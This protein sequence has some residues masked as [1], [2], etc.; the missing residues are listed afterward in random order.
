MQSHLVEYVVVPLGD[1]VVV[2][3]A[4]HRADE[5]LLPVLE[6]V[7]VVV[8]RRVVDGAVHAAGP[9]AAGTGDRDG[10]VGV[11]V[12]VHGDGG[13]GRLLVSWGV[14]SGEG[15]FPLVGQAVLVGVPRER[16]EAAAGAGRGGVA[17]EEV[18]ALGHVG[19]AVAVGVVLPRVGRPVLVGP[20]REAVAVDNRRGV[21]VGTGGV[22]AGVFVGPAGGAVLG[23]RGGDRRARSD[24]AADVVD[25]GRKHHG[26]DAL[27]REV[28][29]VV[30][31]V[32][33]RAVEEVRL[34]AVGAAVAVGVGVQRVG[35]VA[36]PDAHAGAVVVVRGELGERHRPAAGI[37]LRPGGVAVGVL[38]QEVRVHEL[39]VG[40]ERRG[41]G[42]AGDAPRGARIER[43]DG[44]PDLAGAVKLVL[45][46][47][48]VLVDMVVEE[49]DVLRGWA[50]HDRR[51][52]GQEDGRPLLVQLLAEHQP[53]A[54]VVLPDAVGHLRGRGEGRPLGG[55]AGLD[56]VD[57][58][59]GVHLDRL[60]EVVGSAAHVDA[61]PG[62]LGR[63][64]ADEVGA[65]TGHGAE[66]AVGHDVRRRRHVGVGDAA[67]VGEV[68]D[69]RPVAVD[70]LI[71]DVEAL[72]EVGVE[73]RVPFHLAVSIEDADYGEFL[74]HQL[75]L[76][77][78]VGVGG[79]EVG[80]KRVG[81][82]DEHLVAV[83]QAVAV[84]VEV[85]RIGAVLELDEVVE[86]VAVGVNVGEQVVWHVGVVDAFDF[87]G[88]NHRRLGWVLGVVAA[89]DQAAVLAVVVD[90]A[91][92]GTVPDV[93][94]VAVG[95]LVVVGVGQRRVS[96]V[97]GRPE[98]PRSLVRRVMPVLRTPSEEAHVLERGEGG[99][100]VFLRIGVAALG[101]GVEHAGD[102]G[103][104]VEVV[105]PAADLAPRVE[106]HAARHP[107]G[108][109]AGDELRVLH[110]LRRGQV[111][112]V[113][114][115][116]VKPAE[117]VA[118]ERAAVVEDAEAGVATDVD[119]G[120]GVEVEVAEVVGGVVLA[121]KD[122]L[123]LD[124][125]I[126]AVVV[127]VGGR[128]HR[129]EWLGRRGAG[130]RVD[131]LDLPAAA[132][133]V[134]HQPAVEVVV[135]LAR[136]IAVAG[137]LALRGCPLAALRVRL[138][139][140]LEAGGDAERAVVVGDGIGGRIA[141]R[142]EERLGVALGVQPGLLELAHRV[143]LGGALD[144]DVAA[145]EAGGGAV[146]GAGRRARAVGV[147]DYVLGRDDVDVELVRRLAAVAV[148]RRHRDLGVLGVR[149]LEL[150]G[151]GGGGGLRGLRGIG[152][153]VRGGD[154]L[155]R[156]LVVDVGE[157]P[158]DGGV[159]V[160][161][162]GRDVGV[163]PRELDR[164]ARRPFVGGAL[165]AGPVL[166]AGHVERE[167]RRIVVH[168]RDLLLDRGVVLGPG[169][170]VAGCGVGDHLGLDEKRG[171][172]HHRAGA[173][174][175]A[176]EVEIDLDAVAGG[177]LRRLEGNHDALV[178]VHLHH[179]VG[180]DEMEDRARVVLVVGRQRH[181]N[182]Q[183]VGEAET[184]AAGHAGSRPLGY[185]DREEVVVLVGS[186]HI[187]RAIALGKVDNHGRHVA[188]GHGEKVFGV[189]EDVRFV[190]LH[191]AVLQLQGDVLDLPLLL[192][193]KRGGGDA[194]GIDRGD[195]VLRVAVFGVTVGPDPL[196]AG[197]AARRVDGADVGHLDAELHR[198]RRGDATGIARAV[199]HLD[200]VRLLAAPDAVGRVGR[201]DV[202]D[203][204]R[205]GAAQG[206]G[207]D[208]PGVRVKPVLLVLQ[209]HAEVDAAPLDVAVQELD[210]RPHRVLGVV[211]RGVDLEAVRR[212]RGVDEVGARLVHRHDERVHLG[213]RR[214]REHRADVDLL[215]FGVGR[216]GVGR[217]ALVAALEGAG[218]HRERRQGLDGEDRALQGGVAGVAHL[219]PHLH[220]ALER[221]ALGG[222]DDREGNL[223]VL[224][225]VNL[226]GLVHL[227]AAED[228]DDP[229]AIGVLLGE[230]TPVVAHGDVD[231]HRVVLEA[232]GRDG[233][234]DDRLLVG[235]LHRHVA[236]G[237]VLELLVSLRLRRLVDAVGDDYADR[238]QLL[239]GAKRVD[240]EVGLGLAA[241]HRDL[242]EGRGARRVG[243]V[244]VGNE[245]VLLRHRV[246]RRRAD[247]HHQLHLHVVVVK[248]LGEGHLHLR[249]DRVGAR[250]LQRDGAVAVRVG[251]RDER[252][253]RGHH[254]HAAGHQAAIHDLLVGVDRRDLGGAEDDVSPR[255]HRG[256]GPAHELEG[257]EAVRRQLHRINRPRHQLALDAVRNRLARDA[258]HGEDALV[259]APDVDGGGAAF[260][261]GGADNRRILARAVRNALIDV[262]P[263]LVGGIS[264]IGIGRLEV[265]S[266]HIKARIDVFRKDMAPA[267][268]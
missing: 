3:P 215:A 139:R 18:A 237:A 159:L 121:R 98:E 198:R 225:E 213:C 83:G 99:V 11:A 140:E 263:D 253:R 55:D 63:Q 204:K 53:P 60:A 153:R 85:D 267:R 114:I 42:S 24:L 238:L 57:P 67:A 231:V 23:D 35:T 233:G 119:V 230:V 133:L 75:G 232:R 14:G 86:A 229:V 259:L 162:V 76:G 6:T 217:D 39:V 182:I 101:R 156:A 52:G 126:S 72:A 22:V 221:I 61:L 48:A 28:L 142:V 148:A 73:D 50:L 111:V 179:A 87:L 15:D 168:E 26:V 91:D 181:F 192:E 189:T 118:G 138:R 104:V 212:R 165:V 167:L 47:P 195:L 227:G 268:A 49:R 31:Q 90:V 224:G 94:L 191:V 255:A 264:G 97:L 5:V 93:V 226:V 169:L 117:V 223:L 17:I 254:A 154:D 246:D 219:V 183:R 132:V 81:F 151:A 36:L 216:V 178:V 34:P 59:P 252:R 166:G 202:G 103:A 120:D 78:A 207:V 115:E 71:A 33:G 51:S 1:G 92:M 240:V 206:I 220:R 32:R 149:H 130:Q 266:L 122:R 184:L 187:V 105:V 205:P 84:G 65:S 143:L 222:D 249:A 27:A 265:D 25:G 247:A 4:A 125:R 214:R 44:H 134:L 177:L 248:R 128:Q 112:L 211:A 176:V 96:R 135:V 194:V 9:G 203:G 106:R 37:E 38:Q 21:G 141:G 124:G 174:V 131:H 236:V 209:H 56:E 7:V 171:G 152:N 155:H 41:V 210:R 199:G 180:V 2:A 251:E 262:A 20:L 200:A 109:V 123:H 147:D 250:R 19:D 261:L 54:V 172:I 241:R 164:L 160:G 82:G 234:G 95:N 77:V 144:V 69:V 89:A 136:T 190:S 239:A 110:R 79:H 127:G 137:G 80:D 201:R 188:D 170:V 74:D 218:H 196:D 64:V 244:G 12:L 8:E 208:H 146:L 197:G 102:G 185:L 46:E 256:R 163:G 145:A 193:D 242:G 245:D 29:V 88:R 13:G 243:A 161:D 157:R 68:Q 228:D 258:G 107:V 30:R 257:G 66:V 10:G 16:V 158:G 260:V 186:F 113:D 70:R 108:R 129:V 173:A 40:G 45:G 175:L 116:V 62:R 100:G 150:V 235:H 58:E 43:L